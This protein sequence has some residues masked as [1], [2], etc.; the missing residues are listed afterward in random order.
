[1]I[2][3]MISSTDGW[4]EG[5]LHSKCWGCNSTGLGRPLTPTHLYRYGDGIDRY[6]IYV[7]VLLMVQHTAFIVSTGVCREI[8]P[9]LL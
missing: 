1:M 7:H 2:M 9:L 5:Q 6:D 3:D 8:S 4:L